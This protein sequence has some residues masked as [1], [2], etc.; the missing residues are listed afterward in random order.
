MKNDFV[1]LKDIETTRHLQPF[2]RDDVILLTNWA[3]QVRSEKLDFCLSRSA[4]KDRDTATW[5]NGGMIVLQSRTLGMDILL[6]KTAAFNGTCNK[7][8]GYHFM[9]GSYVK[10]QWE[11]GTAFRSLRAG[12]EIIASLYP[13]TKTSALT[14]VQELS[15]QSDRHHP[16][17]LAHSA[18]QSKKSMNAY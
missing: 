6:T 7:D 3:V 13:P 9:V 11:E 4:S 17:D 18:R 8:G 10:D 12:L 2:A 14:E 15:L 1:S 16:S 5:I